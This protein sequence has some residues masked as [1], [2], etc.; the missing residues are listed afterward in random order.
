MGT[1]LTSDPTRWSD[2]IKKAAAKL[3]GYD[4]TGSIQ[5]LRVKKKGN[6]T[7]ILS[8]DGATG[9]IHPVWN[10]PVEIKKETKKS[11]QYTYLLWALAHG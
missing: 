2:K 4:V 7:S 1:S 5:L 10:T 3:S 9:T 8:R 11:V 6:A